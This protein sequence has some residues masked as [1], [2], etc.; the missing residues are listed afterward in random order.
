MGF[1]K[2]PDETMLERELRAQRPQPRSE[3]VRML[4]G[5]I[6]P[7]QRP[8]R[9][10]L[11]KIALVAAVSAALAASL[12]ATGALG[13]A[14]GSV[15][16]FG[17]SVVHL[18]SAPKPPVVSHPVTN[19]VTGQTT[20]SGGVAPAHYPFQWQY[21][22]QVSVCWHGEIIQIPARELFFY[23]RRGARPPGLCLTW[24]PYPKHP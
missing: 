14:G 7:M 12:G 10:T 4:S 22:H 17:L 21:G 15:H 19:P 23:L 16:T 6:A 8:R 5:R 3:L 1:G 9:L 13:A 11:P 24:A 20:T 2:K 18:V